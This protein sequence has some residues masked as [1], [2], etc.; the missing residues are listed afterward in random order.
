MAPNNFPITGIFASGF[1]VLLLASLVSLAVCCCF[2]E[3]VWFAFTADDV[4]VGGEGD[5]EE[6]VVWLAVDDGDATVAVV[7][8]LEF[9]AG[10]DV[11]DDGWEVREVDDRLD[12]EGDATVAVLD[13]PVTFTLENEFA[14]GLLAHSYLDVILFSPGLIIV[15]F[16]VMSNFHFE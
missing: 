4:D 12:E 9:V 2:E 13:M 1:A 3:V 7:A 10:D 5:G 8:A 6:E 15:Y 11:P 16:D 14:S